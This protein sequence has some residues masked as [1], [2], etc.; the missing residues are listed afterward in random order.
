VKKR[1]Y[2]ETDDEDID[3]FSN[4]NCIKSIFSMNEGIKSATLDSPIMRAQ[5]KR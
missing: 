3:L 4:S 5:F 2:D 1:R